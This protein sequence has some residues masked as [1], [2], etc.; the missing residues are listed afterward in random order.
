M[1]AVTLPT[2][3][4][5][6]RYRAFIVSAGGEEESALGGVSQT[7]LR[8]GDKFGLEV[9]LPPQ[10]AGDAA[11]NW[12]AALMLG[13]REGVRMRW[14]QVGLSIGN[15]GS[16]LVNG[17]GQSGSTLNMDGGAANYPAK[18]GQFF[19]FDQGGR[20]YLHMLYDAN[21]FNGA[22]ARALTLVNPL[23]I[24]P[25]D[26]TPLNFAEPML[27]GKLIGDDVSWEVNR[28]RHY[29]LNFTVVAR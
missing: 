14:P 17:A 4:G 7:I 22:G 3:P 29:G 1:V 21:T 24:I 13:R 19:S 6:V 23:R 18:S 20:T 16:P 15:P 9:S 5:N 28:A 12:C 11:L 26:N 27:E 25:A 10:V 8:L 2:S